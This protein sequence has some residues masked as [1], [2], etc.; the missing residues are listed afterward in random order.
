[1]KIKTLIEGKKDIRFIDIPIQWQDNF[2]KF[3]FGQTYYKDDDGNSIM[4]YDD[5][6]RWY[7]INQV[8]IDREIKIDNIIE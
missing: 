4:Y 8:A 1:M 3:M 2:N 7:W 5:F 6:M